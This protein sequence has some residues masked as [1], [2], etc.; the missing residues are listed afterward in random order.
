MK[1]FAPSAERNRDEILGALKDVLPA[2]GTIL[3]IASGTGQHAVHFAPH[4]PGATW[5]PSERRPE[6]LASIHAWAA[7][8]RHPNLAEPL[9]I[10]VTWDEWPVAELSAIV[11]INM[12]HI[13][14]WAACEGLLAGAARVL[15]P[16]APLFYYGAFLHDDRETAPS[17]LAF[18][19]SLRGRD[20]S[21]GIRRF[22]EV[23][24]AA[25]SRGLV[26]DRLVDMPNNNY[27]LVIRQ[28]RRGC[29]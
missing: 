13:S 3:E 14:P 28:S 17:N 29:A 4:F 25:E 20:P 22:E 24:A 1:D 12:L 10:D 26:F 2:E 9:E 23:R 15:R 11:A 6:A 8:A 7:E 21:W 5:Q 19:R 27:S 16:G 18:D